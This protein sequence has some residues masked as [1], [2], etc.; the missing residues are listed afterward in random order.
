MNFPVRSGRAAKANGADR[1][2]VFDV[3]DHPMIPGPVPNHLPEPSLVFPGPDPGFS[4]ASQTCE[5][6]IGPVQDAGL[7]PLV[8][9]TEL[10][11]GLYFNRRP[12]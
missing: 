6:I 12:R 10:D 9:R 7:I 1:A 2:A 5:G 3:A 4:A 11:L 8:Y